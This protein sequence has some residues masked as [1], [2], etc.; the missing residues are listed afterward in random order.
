M[1]AFDIIEKLPQGLLEVETCELTRVCPRPTL[2]ELYPAGGACRN[3]AMF[4]S[5]T[6]HGNEDAGLLAIQQ[7]FRLC[8]PEQL[9]R[10]F[11]IFVANVE[12]TRHGVR[13][14]DSQVDFNRSWPG[15]DQRSNAIQQMLAEIYKRVAS[16]P[17][18]ASID[19]HNNTGRNPHYGCICSLNALHLNLAS[20]FSDRLIYFTR[21]RGVQ[22]QAFMDLCP[23]VTLECGRIG[24][25]EGAHF[26]ARMLDKCMRTEEFASI[27]EG[28]KLDVMRTCARIQVREGC[29]VGFESGADIVLREDIDLL[30]FR[31]IPAGEPIGRLAKQLDRCIAVL[32]SD[33][34]DVTSHFVNDSMGELRFERSVTPSMLTKDLRVM[35]QDCLGYLMD[36]VNGADFP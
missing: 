5:I 18:H 30:N 1:D 15:T 24:E 11:K 27:Q 20:L 33:G 7:F 31:K 34:N 26:A 3:A 10:P 36:Q 35:R 21:P 32:D 2:I 17:L 12:A 28:R 13:Y 14:T 4:V 9:T 16:E 19:I 22:T 6:Q 25:L 29:T 8:S 23:S